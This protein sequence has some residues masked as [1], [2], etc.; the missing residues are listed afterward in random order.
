[1]YAEASVESGNKDLALN[2]LSEIL[3]RNSTYKKATELYDTLLQQEYLPDIEIA[4]TAIKEELLYPTGDI[5]YDLYAIPSHN[6]QAYYAIV[7]EEDGKYKMVYA[8]TEIHDILSEEPIKMYTFED[9][10]TAKSKPNS[11]GRI[12]IGMAL[13]GKG[14]VDTLRDISI[15]VSAGKKAIKDGVTIDGVFQVIRAFKGTETVK[16]IVYEDVET[17]SVLKNDRDYKA[18]LENMYLTVE[19][20]IS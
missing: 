2:L 17:I 14:F 16:E 13:P 11:D 6:H 5:L 8:K 9:A 18:I 10:T 12:I 1:M 3:H 15:N 7:F 4:K 20:I 19:K